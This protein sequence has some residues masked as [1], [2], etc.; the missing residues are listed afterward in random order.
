MKAL[1]YL[2]AGA[3]IGHFSHCGQYRYRLWRIWDRDMPRICFIMLNPSTADGAE[4][5][6][7]IRK[8]VGFARRWGYGSLVVVNLYAYRSTD[9]KGL[10]GVYDAVGPGNRTSVD[11]ALAQ[12]ETVVCAWG[13]TKGE[14]HDIARYRMIDA[15]N[16]HGKNPMCLG[17]T[18][19]GSPRHPLYVRNDQPLMTFDEARAARTLKGDQP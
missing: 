11:I 4:D 18:K 7:T 15:I 6:P 10:R 19:D 8:C 1:P 13:A 2:D 9:P 12:S 17:V 3:S 16:A 14:D 5:D